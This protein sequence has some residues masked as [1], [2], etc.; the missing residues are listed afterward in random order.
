[1]K[2]LPCPH[3]DRLLT[4]TLC[5]GVEVDR[6]GGCGGTWFDAMEAEQLKAIAGSEALDAV[7]EPRAT[8]APPAGDRLCPRCRLKMTRIL[9]M[10]EYDVWYEQ[11]PRCGGLWLDAGE[12]RQFKENFRARNFFDRARQHLRLRT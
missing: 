12:F 10:D 2:A 8:S 9:D 5:A 11:C 3:C 1:M 4:P 6:C 7:Q